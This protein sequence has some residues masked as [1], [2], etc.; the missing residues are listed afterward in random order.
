MV[1]ELPQLQ[2]EV[3]NLPIYAIW[4]SFNPLSRNQIQHNHLA[5]SAAAKT[6]LRSLFALL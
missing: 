3:G 1:R 5:I 2:K 4:M 6:I